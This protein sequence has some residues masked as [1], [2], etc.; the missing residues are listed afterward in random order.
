MSNFLKKIQGKKTYII[1]GLSMVIAVLQ[2]SGIEIPTYVWTILG[3]AGLGGVR[4]AISKV[5]APKN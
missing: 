4:S 2:L 3:A 5:G 1:M